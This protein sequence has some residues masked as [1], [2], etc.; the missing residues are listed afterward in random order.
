MT[1]NSKP[2]T[3]EASGKSLPT[4]HQ[5]VVDLLQRNGGATLEE[6]SVLS[7]WLPHSTR[8]FMSGLKKKGYVV[9]SEKADGIRRYR[10]VRAE[11]A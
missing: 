5:Q 6:M 8:A 1:T 2:R 11:A 9:E 7:K 4:K 3:N 10:I